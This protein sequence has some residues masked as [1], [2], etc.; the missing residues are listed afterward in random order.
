[1][2]SP[3]RQCRCFRLRKDRQAAG[4]PE[5]TARLDLDGLDTF[6]KGAAAHPRDEGIA[7]SK[8]SLLLSTYKG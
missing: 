2:S 6:D 3:R 7:G 4:W 8:I 5:F 1:M